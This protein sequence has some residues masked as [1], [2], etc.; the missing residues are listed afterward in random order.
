MFYIPFHSIMYCRLQVLSFQ[1]MLE[2]LQYITLMFFMPCLQN[3]YIFYTYSTSQLGLTTFQGLNNHI[4][5]VATLVGNT[6]LK[7]L[8]YLNAASSHFLKL[9]HLQSTK[10][11]RPR[12]F[13]VGDFK[14][15]NSTSL[16]AVGLFRLFLLV[17]YVC[18]GDGPFYLSC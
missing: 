10:P 7:F 17:I 9:N 15:M 18:Q 14:T 4:R 1:T 6:V 16:I 12:V 2:I 8:L 5:L 3:H 11:S 13:F